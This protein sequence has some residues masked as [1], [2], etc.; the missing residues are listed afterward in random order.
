MPVDEEYLQNVMRAISHDMGGAL[1]VAVGF[2]T[3][4]LEKNAETLDE[5][6]IEWLSLIKNDGK[7]SQD[8]LIALSRYARLYNME[9]DEQKECDISTI[10]KDVVDA[11]GI[12]KNYPEFSVNI[13]PKLPNIMGHKTLW[14]ELLSEIITNSAIHSTNSSPVTC[15]IYSIVTT[16]QI[17]IIIEDNG[18]GLTP[19]QIKLAF[20]PFRSMDG[21]GVGMGL[22]ISKRIAEIEGGQL[23]VE[24]GENEAGLKVL[25]NLPISLLIC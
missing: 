22:S 13:A 8:K 14:S 20:S 19:K 7:K 15:R 10:C 4:L 11:L 21:D 2:S 17:S 5:K 6:A 1:R 9:L 25:I 3:L 16:D 12:E 23:Q 18:I 24:Q